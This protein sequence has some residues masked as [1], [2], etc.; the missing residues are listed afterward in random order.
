MHNIVDFIED[1]KFKDLI[2]QL[3]KANT[4]EEMNNI[5]SRH[6]KMLLS[7]EEKEQYAIAVAL[8]VENYLKVVDEDIEELR[9]ATIRRKM[10]ELDK[11]I[12]FAYIAKNYFGKS[13]SWLLQRLNGS[14]V[15][16]KEARFNKSELLQLQDA[17]H[18]LGKK[19]SALVL[20]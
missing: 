9:S 17:I 8:G 11:A 16:G 18:D 14:K 7:A 19:L 6:N 3:G 4:E 1:P 20:L 5:I 13:Q 10:G 12:S 2:Q 15:N